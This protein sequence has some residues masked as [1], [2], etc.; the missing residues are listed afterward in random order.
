MMSQA[1]RIMLILHA[2]DMILVLA[3]SSM[4]MEPSAKPWRFN[5]AHQDRPQLPVLLHVRQKEHV[6]Q[7][8]WAEFVHEHH[9][10][11]A[12]IRRGDIILNPD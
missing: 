8:I 10:V 7:K 3:E 11:G 5:S 1:C 4:T 6:W 12:H 2:A 9:R